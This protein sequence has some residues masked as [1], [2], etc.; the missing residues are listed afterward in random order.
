[1]QQE[2]RQSVIHLIAERSIGFLRKF[3]Q[4]LLIISIYTKNQSNFEAEKKIR[5]NMH[6]F[7]ERRLNDYKLQFN[8][9]FSINTHEQST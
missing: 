9:L 3:F 5:V 7:E 8:F 4:A 6:F 1:M 2:Y